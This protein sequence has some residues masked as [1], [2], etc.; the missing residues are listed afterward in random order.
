MNSRRLRARSVAVGMAAGLLVFLVFTPGSGSSRS[1]GAAGTLGGSAGS[2]IALPATPSAVT[3]S[4]TGKF[5]N[6]KVTVNQ[7]QNLV[8]QVVS[9]TWTGGTPTQTGTD[10]LSIANN[11]LQFMQCWGDDGTGTGPPPEQCEFG[12]EAASSQGN[13]GR[14]QVAPNP[15]AYPVNSY[16]FAF[17]RGIAQAGT[18]CGPLEPTTCRSFAQLQTLAQ[19]NP[20]KATYD[21]FEQDIFDPFNPV[22][23]ASVPETV[24]EHCCLGTQPWTSSFDQNPY[25]NHN[26]SNEV[27]FAR[28]YADG[29]GQQLFTVDTGLEAPGLG[30]GQAQQNPDGSAGPPPKCWLVVV[31]RGDPQ[32]ENP[33]EIAGLNV[34]TSPLAPGP[35]SNRIAIPLSFQP[36]GTSCVQGGTTR[37]IVGGELAGSAVGSWQPTLCAQPGAPDY[38]YA[39]IGDDS[40]RTQLLGRTGV[41][42]AVVTRPID[43]STVDPTNPL[44]YAPLTL[45]GLVL[46]FNIER[47]PVYTPIIP[48]D[49]RPIIGTHITKLNLTPRL[50]AK[51]LTASYREAFGP[52]G[53]PTDVTSSWA[54]KN[55]TNLV[56]DPDFLHYNPEFNELITDFPTDAAQLIVEQPSSD[57]AYELWQWILGDPAAK[58]FLGGQPDPWGMQVNPYYSTDVSANPS[59]AA[60]DSPAIDNFPKSD[61]YCYVPTD[62]AYEVGYPPAE[63]RPLCFQDWSPYTLNLNASAAAL[64]AANSGAKTAINPAAPNAAAGWGSNGPQADQTHFMMG[65]TTT[66]LAFRYGLQTASL[67]QDGDDGPNAVFISPDS[68]GLTAGEGAMQP[69]NVSGVLAPNVG[70]RAAGAY[71]LTM[72]TYAAVAPLGLDNTSRTDYAA[73]LTYAAGKGQV[74][75]ETLGSLPTGY[76]PL[77]AGLVSQTTEAAAT[78]LNPAALAP[79]TTTTTVA[80]PTT[81]AA[82]SPTTSAWGT[83]PP[84]APVPPNAP[85]GQSAP[86]PPARY[87]PVASPSPPPTLATLPAASKAANLPQTGGPG[88]TAAPRGRT[89]ATKPGAT[90]YAFVLALLVGLGAAAGTQVVGSRRP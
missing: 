25:F 59:G 63:A 74:P 80:P 60:F 79:T 14:P 61:P 76:V 31:P 13:P 39:G 21:S 89:A 64:A 65:L 56:N 42:M 54:A 43:P 6:L 38:L 1:S 33:P 86:S 2:D 41:G 53:A 81:V 45:S 12:A 3:V 51:L 10:G 83:T 26:T 17:T 15:G 67:S 30:C 82:A 40:A 28:T 49:E 73:F 29:T 62:V 27:D 44:V 32:N 19:T 68:N 36:I 35:W 85:A 57:V 20:A 88:Q 90:R 5:A 50:V 55:P 87:T 72:L 34:D 37:R 75:G 52:F 46:G 23:G 9:V 4:G 78:V 66:D 77:P 8:N 48:A 70:T 18:S 84:P 16:T 47:T 11:F 24:D 69:S 58:A 71:P 7:T 22:Q